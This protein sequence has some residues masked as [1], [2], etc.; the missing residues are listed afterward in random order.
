[1]AAP[2]LDADLLNRQFV[3]SLPEVVCSL[4]RA[5]S[6]RAGDAACAR[7]HIFVIMPINIG[8]DENGGACGAVPCGGIIAVVLALA[9]PPIAARWLA[10][11][12]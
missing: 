3:A 4:R 7:Q 12:G 11:I 5:L 6:S 8:G 1:M 10:T 9:V 2:G